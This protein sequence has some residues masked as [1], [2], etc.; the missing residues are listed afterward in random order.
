MEDGHSKFD[1]PE[2]ARTLLL[3]FAAGSAHLAT[4]DGAEFGVVQALLARP[5][6]LL[7][8]RL[9]I[10]DMA[11]AHALDLIG[12]KETELNLLHRL[13]RRRGVRKGCHVGRSSETSRVE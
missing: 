2:M 3:A 12:R 6:A 9:G 8:H 7:V 13:E 1:V 4:I 10:F 5:V 11:H